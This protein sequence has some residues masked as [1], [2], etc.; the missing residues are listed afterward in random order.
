M[1]NA[2]TMI[3]LIFVIVI[4]GILSA[5]AIPKFG[6]TKNQADIAQAK[7]TIASIRSGIVSER[8]T[9]LITGDSDWIT[10][11]NLDTA[12]GLFGGVLMYAI[13]NSDKNGH[14]HTDDDDDEGD[15]DYDFKLNGIDVNF[16][17]DDSD[18]TFICDVDN[19]DFG[20]LCGQLIN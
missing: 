9:R 11:A 6:N 16:A 13:P 15:G 7:S 5:V 20:T 1:K 10:N 3:E 18:G 17:Y 19:A 4:L 12:A 2:F 8:Q 14:W